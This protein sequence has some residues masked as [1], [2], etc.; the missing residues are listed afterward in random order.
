MLLT[1]E[2]DAI[3]GYV[4]VAEQVGP[5]QPEKK[6]NHEDDDAHCKPDVCPGFLFTVVV[7]HN[8]FCLEFVLCSNNEACFLVQRQPLRSI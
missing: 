7:V 3:G 6:Q 4:G 1:D 2:A 5:G 8:A